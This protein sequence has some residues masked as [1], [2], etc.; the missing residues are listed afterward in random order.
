MSITTDNPPTRE[1]SSMNEDARSY[2]HSRKT[3]AAGLVLVVVAIVITWALTSGN[4]D[5]NSAAKPAPAPSGSACGLTGGDS[6]IP[7][8]TPPTQW[9]NTNGWYLAISTTDGPSRRSETG[10]WACYS[11]TPTGAV[12]AAWDIGT[13][14]GLVKDTA[15]IIAQQVAPGAGQS[16]L[17]TQRQQP[18]P[19]DTV[20]PRGFRVDSW[21]P[22]AAQLSFW[23]HQAGK[24]VLCSSRVQWSD[25]THDWLLS[26][27][28]NGDTS[29][30]CQMTTGT[31]PGAV[32]WSPRS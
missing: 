17:L 8:T 15:T 2:W 7:T 18:L 1:G 14:I 6:R 16:A 3:L 13:R 29:A 24:D 19:L 28:A 9:V 26:P 5:K 30:G 11:R 23:L 10:P 20:V 21:T 25:T 27:E 12:L 32:S 4:H 22:N 31:P